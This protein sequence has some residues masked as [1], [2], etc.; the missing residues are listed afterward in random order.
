MKNSDV[1]GRGGG[2][3]KIMFDTDVEKC[4]ARGNYVT[5]VTMVINTM[6]TMVTIV[7]M[8]TMIT[9]VTI[10]YHK[11]TVG[12]LPALESRMFYRGILLSSTM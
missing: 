1:W 7:T 11:G 8:I 2:N 5:V 12:N 4:I 9:M 3:C 10:W 6:I